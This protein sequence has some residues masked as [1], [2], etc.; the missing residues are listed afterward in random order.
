MQKISLDEILA[1]IEQGICFEAS[2]DDDFFIKIHEYVPVVCAAIHNGHRLRPALEENCLLTDKERLYEEDPHT[3]TFIQS[4]PI[5]L[6]GNDSRYEYDL[7]RGV[8]NCVY[9]SAWGKEV[10][11]TPLT[12]AEKALSLEKHQRFY[13][14]VKALISKL[15]KMFQAVIVYDLHSYN[16]KRHDQSFLFNIG[17]ENLDI[18]RYNRQITHWKNALMRMK[19]SRL[20]P[21]VSVNHI[22]YGRGELLRFVREHFNNTLVMATEVKK[23]FMNEDTGQ[24]Y[25][26]VI[27][28]LAKGFK[29]AITLNSQQ[30]INDRSNLNFS[31]KEDVLSSTLPKNVIQF[32]QKLF[33]L[34]S[35]FELLTPI[36]PINLEQEKRKFFK[37]NFSENPSFRYKPLTTDAHEFKANM[38]K[39]PIAEIEDVHIRQ[40]YLDVIQAYSDKIDML[41]TIGTDQFFFNSLRHFGAPNEK[42]I[43][44]AQF[45]LF[46]KTPNFGEEE[47]F[48]AAQAKDYFYEE[49]AQYGFN[50]NIEL[51]ENQAADAYVLSRRRKL[52]LKKSAL[53]NK[54]R[55]NALLHH[56]IGVHV[57]T[58]VNA[59]EQPLKLFQLGMPEYTETQEGLAILSELQS[60]FL[61]VKR[62]RQLA[63]RVMAVNSLIQ[64]NDFK[65]TYVQ[66]LE[67]Y[68][69]DPNQLYYIVARVYRG[70]GFTKDYLYLSGF[71]RILQLQSKGRDL[72]NLF[73]G[74][75]AIKYLPI[76]NELVDRG[77]L[78]KVQHLPKPYLKPSEI[79]PVLQYLSQSLI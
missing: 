3:A 27:Q 65:T 60:G 42:D 9:E 64:G 11:K 61:E 70:G 29:E 78:N 74:K 68:N 72:N 2:H 75:T 34:L 15:E 10:W 66:L 8:E 55:L 35:K 44:N 12:E 19:S 26:K 30:F 51:K 6:I 7:N 76:L 52:L 14:V 16:Y 54:N 79:D 58:G 25:P 24:P 71:K 49:G 56:E 46:G 4:M 32:D 31:H 5:T 28:A 36:N 38:Y 59:E 77:M 53:F 39:L 41:N 17:I 48:D 73:I 37:M 20:I 50:F 1:N 40:L 13:Q 43:A 67:N 69:P 23:I 63:L 57:L 33:K 21:D 62:L 22:F 47:I 18:P 45:L